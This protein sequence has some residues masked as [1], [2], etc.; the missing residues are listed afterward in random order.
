MSCEVLATVPSRSRPTACSKQMD[1]ECGHC[2]YSWNHQHSVVRNL[3]VGGD[4]VF[5]KGIANWGNYSSNVSGVN[6]LNSPVLAATSH[7]PY[8]SCVSELVSS[9]CPFMY[10]GMVVLSTYGCLQLVHLRFGERSP[11]VACDATRQCRV[12]KIGS[13]HL[14]TSRRALA[15]RYCNALVAAMPSGANIRMCS[16]LAESV[17]RHRVPRTCSLAK[18]TIN[19]LRLALFVREGRVAYGPLWEWRHLRVA[20]FGAPMSP[21]SSLICAR[22]TPT[23][24][25][26][27]D[28]PNRR[29]NEKTSPVYAAPSQV[30]A[31][32]RL[33]T[34]RCSE[35]EGSLVR[36]EVCR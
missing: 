22:A 17:R 3:H 14:R 8:L 6:Q 15:N 27:L 12:L 26:V 7:V 4:S 20:Y 36:A 16:L 31:G 11:N 9:N 18:R 2:L 29:P 35:P 5:A 33:R 1:R 32:L 30:D 25:A 21:R 23:V 24:V 19:Q 28:R 10:L 13:P 34:T